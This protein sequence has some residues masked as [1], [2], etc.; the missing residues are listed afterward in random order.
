VHHRRE[1]I[2]MAD[3]AIVVDD[4]RIAHDTGGLRGATTHNR[5]AA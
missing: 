3:R 1:T 5:L 4:G 2:E